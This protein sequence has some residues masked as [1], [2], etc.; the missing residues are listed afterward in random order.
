MQYGEV[1]SEILHFDQNDNQQ[2]YPLF[3]PRLWG[4]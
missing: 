2:M 4:Y 3:P 1:D